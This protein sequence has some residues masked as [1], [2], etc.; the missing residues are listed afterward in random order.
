MVHVCLC[1][2]CRIM[3]VLIERGGR[4]HL[5]LSHGAGTDDP[6]R[7]MYICVW[8]IDVRKVNLVFS[9]S[10]YLRRRPGD[11][12]TEPALFSS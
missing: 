11:V 10:S 9:S 7:Y 3:K 2:R 5:P 6:P 12:Y 1:L 4:P 8:Y